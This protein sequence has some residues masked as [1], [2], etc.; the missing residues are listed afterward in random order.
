MIEIS[1]PDEN[2]NLIFETL[3]RSG[4]NKIRREFHFLNQ[5]KY[6]K[7]LRMMRHLCCRPCD[8]APKIIPKI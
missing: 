8:L 3:T 2:V 6:N 4:D 5:R 1:F 7:I